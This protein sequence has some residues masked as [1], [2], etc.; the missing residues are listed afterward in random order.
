MRQ[1][2]RA[3]NLT[4]CYRKKQIDVSFNASVLLLTMNFVITL[5]KRSLDPQL[6]WQVYD[7]KK[8]GNGLLC[9]SVS[10]G[11]PAFNSPIHTPG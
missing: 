1:G 9:S 11:Y 8:F 3:D 6:L 7:E 2:T 10:K 4:I 5:L